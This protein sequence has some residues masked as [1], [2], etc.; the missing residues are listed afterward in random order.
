MDN[1]KW[2]AHLP[3][4]DPD[5]DLHWTDVIVDIGVIDK[6]PQ[7]IVASQL[8]SDDLNLLKK[9]LFNELTKASA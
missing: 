9:R 6:P 7:V 1:I 3:Q 8:S 5:I 2:Q 4:C